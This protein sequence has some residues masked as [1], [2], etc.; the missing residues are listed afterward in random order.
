M[1][2]FPTLFAAIQYIYCININI[3]LYYMPNTIAILI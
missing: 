3:I 2:V 1:F